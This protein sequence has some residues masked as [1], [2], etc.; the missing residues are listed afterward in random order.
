MPVD[1]RLHGVVVQAL[2]KF[3]DPPAP[4]AHSRWHTRYG[5]LAAAKGYFGVQ[6]LSCLS[7]FRSNCTQLESL[8]PAMAAAIAAIRATGVF[9][10]LRMA[11]TSFRADIRNATQI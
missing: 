4:G 1:Q 8:G 2:R 7:P 3:S 5:I 9:S 6:S 11:F 10:M